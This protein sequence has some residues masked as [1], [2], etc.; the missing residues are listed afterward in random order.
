MGLCFQGAWEFK[1]ILIVGIE[2]EDD[3][4]AIPGGTSRIWFQWGII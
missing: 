3:V 1:P 4:G 2:E